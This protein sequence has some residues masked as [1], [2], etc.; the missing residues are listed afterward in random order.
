MRVT[1]E[2]IPIGTVRN[3][4]V[5]QRVSFAVLSART[6]TS[7]SG[8]VLLRGVGNINESEFITQIVL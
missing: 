7:V 6:D 5:T 4:I 8:N 1:Q 3:G 2:M